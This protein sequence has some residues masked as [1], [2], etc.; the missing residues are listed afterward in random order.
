MPHLAK[1]GA[2]RWPEQ[3]KSPSG[4]LLHSRSQKNES[5]QHIAQLFD[6]SHLS[7]QWILAESGGTDSPL[8]SAERLQVPVVFF[9]IVD[10]IGVNRPGGTLSHKVQPHD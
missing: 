1:A 5:L 2:C 7:I 3:S 6:R 10:G 4:D 9:G 8:W